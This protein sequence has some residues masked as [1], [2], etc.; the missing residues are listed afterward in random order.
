MRRKCLVAIS[1]IVRCAPARSRGR[2]RRGADRDVPADESAQPGVPGGSELVRDRAGLEDRREG[3]RINGGSVLEPDSYLLVAEAVGKMCTGVIERII[4]PFAA[5]IC[6]RHP[7]I[8]GPV[9]ATATVGRVDLCSRAVHHVRQLQLRDIG[10]DYLA[11]RRGTSITRDWA[12]GGHPK[13]VHIGV[14]LRDA[15]L[16]KFDSIDASVARRSLDAI[17]RLGLA[18]AVL[19]GS[20]RPERLR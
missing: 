16:E 4:Q 17:E 2:V 18:Q 5:R 15:D 20:S 6:W 8:P 10:V 12:I 19:R 3:D 1:R 7:L 11:W 9:F 14:V 13:E